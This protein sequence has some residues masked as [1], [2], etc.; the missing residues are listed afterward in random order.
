MLDNDIQD[1]LLL[2]D[3][4]DGYDCSETRRGKVS[5]RHNYGVTQFFLP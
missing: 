5:E 3:C 1:G 4:G 2:M